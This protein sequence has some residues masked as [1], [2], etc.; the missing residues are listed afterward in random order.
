MLEVYPRQLYFDKTSHY[1]ELITPPYT[2]ISRDNSSYFIGS[3]FGQIKNAQIAGVIGPKVGNGPH[4]AS[5]STPSLLEVFSKHSTDCLDGRINHRSEHAV[6]GGG[7][8]D[9]WTGELEQQKVALKTIRGF[10]SMG[11]PLLREKLLKRLWREYLVWS[12]LKHP[13]ILQCLGFSYD[14]TPS[15]PFKLPALVSPWMSNGTAV[16]YI[17]SK[18]D[19]DRLS[20]IMGIITGLV[21]LHEREVV[22]GDIRAGNILVSAEGIPHL[23]DFGLSRILDG[24]VGVTTSSNVAGSLRWMSHEL[25]NNQKADK[26]SDVWA[27]GMTVLEIL[28]GEQ[29]YAEIKL[30]PAVLML[31]I[32]GIFPS[33]PKASFAPALTDEMWKI[34]CLCWRL[35]PKKRPHI[36]EIHKKSKHIFEKY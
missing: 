14:T 31:I 1:N 26:K 28:T 36:H 20:L 22:H 23:T 35:D 21:F 6:T 27:F 3:P 17:R 5:S 9:I 15:S 7:Y 33:R 10:G 25:I 4:V 11:V 12:Q 2:P 32:K 18:P 8:A 16:S 13:N 34:C 30:D 24:T 29:P 19:V